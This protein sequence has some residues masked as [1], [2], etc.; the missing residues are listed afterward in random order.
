MQNRTYFCF[1]QFLF[2]LSQV[3]P[4]RVHICR[5]KTVKQNAATV[6][7]TAALPPATGR[8]SDQSKVFN[9]RDLNEMC[10]QSFNEAIVNLKQSPTWMRLSSLSLDHLFTKKHPIIIRN[11]SQKLS[12]PMST[13]WAVSYKSEGSFQENRGECTNGSSKF[14]L[15]NLSF[16]GI[17]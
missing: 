15:A 2:H 9:A 4:R 5:K 10:A 7:T 11:N 13:P 14:L 17:M 6:Q 3:K 1:Q 16:S 12:G 8:E